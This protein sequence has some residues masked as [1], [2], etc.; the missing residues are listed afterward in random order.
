M[1]RILVVCPL[2]A[3]SIGCSQPVAAPPQAT[4]PAAQVAVVPASAPVVSTA[5]DADRQKAMTPDQ[6]LAALKEGNERFVSGKMTARDYTKQVAATAAGQYPFASIVSCIDSRSGPELVFDQ[7]IGDIFAPR[8]A[9]NFVNEDILGSLEFTTK[10]AGS[11]LV[12]VLGHTAC[13]AIKGACDNVKLGNLTGLLAKLR[14]VVDSVEHTGDRSGKN[15]EFV[16]LVATANVKDAVS[17]I[18]KNSPVLAEME[19]KGKIRIVGAMLDITSGKV[20]FLD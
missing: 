1:V 14:T 3:L 15:A 17:D 2:V 11:K 10:A 13:G 4:A 8:I 19:Q 18:R 20:T 5:M 6:A 9:G 12:V 7:G 16:D